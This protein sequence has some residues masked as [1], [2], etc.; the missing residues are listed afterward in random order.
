MHQAGH[1]TRYCS[2]TGIAYENDPQYLPNLP[3]QALIAKPTSRNGQQ[4]RL[5]EIVTDAYHHL[6]CQFQFSLKRHNHAFDFGA[7]LFR[8][9][10]FLG[11]VKTKI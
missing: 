4:C 2:A 3:P 9:N 5:G 6:P 10:G 8:I 1:T 7:S 11:E